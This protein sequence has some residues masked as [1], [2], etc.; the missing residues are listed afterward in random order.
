MYSEDLLVQMSKQNAT[1]DKWHEMFIAEEEKKRD[2][3]LQ[4]FS[5]Q[6]KLKDILNKP[7]VETKDQ[8]VQVNVPQPRPAP[9][10]A[11]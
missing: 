6:N 2:L 5:A 1:G 7:K 8:E 10:P 3:T 4:L 11:S 9:Q